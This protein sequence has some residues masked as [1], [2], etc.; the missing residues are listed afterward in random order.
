MRWLVYEFYNF[1]YLKQEGFLQGCDF[2]AIEEDVL[3]IIH[4]KT[5]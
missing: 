2:E 4:K 5:V 3:Y 1:K